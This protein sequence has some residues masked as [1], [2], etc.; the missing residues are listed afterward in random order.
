MQQK[1]LERLMGIAFILLG[2]YLVLGFA[3]S[4][5]IGA[6]ASKDALLSV[7]LIFGIAAGVAFIVAG[8]AL[9]MDSRH[10]Q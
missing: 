6:S 5:L 2:I 8:A 7:T 1:T 3:R 4:I 9:F 10:A